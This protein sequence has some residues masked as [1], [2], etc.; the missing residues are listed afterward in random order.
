MQCWFILSSLATSNM[1]WN[2]L[3]ALI[4]RICC[5]ACSI[6]AS[7]LEFG[8]HSLHG[9]WGGCLLQGFEMQPRRVI[10]GGGAGKYIRQ[11][12]GDQEFLTP[13]FH[14]LLTVKDVLVRYFYL[15]LFL[16]NHYHQPH[17]TRYVCTLHSPH[18]S[19]FGL[20]HFPNGEWGKW[21]SKVFELRPKES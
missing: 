6:R 17:E 12:G 19:I 14:F 2:F 15:C 8:I 18:H 9:E 10:M 20:I 13:P 4:F 16:F 11:I 21:V 3:N 7:N 1:D 5:I